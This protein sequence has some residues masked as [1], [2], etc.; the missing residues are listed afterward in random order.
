MLS[1]LPVESIMKLRFV[2][3]L[4]VLLAVVAPVGN[5]EAQAYPSRPIKIVV[6]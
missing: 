2:A 5:V 1:Q 3:S 6:P 4:A